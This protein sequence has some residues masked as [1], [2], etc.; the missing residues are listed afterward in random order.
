[1]DYFVPEK[2]PLPRNVLESLVWDRE[3]DIERAKE[4]FALPRAMGIA[5]L[6]DVKYPKRSLF[7]ALKPV[8]GSKTLPFILSAVRSSLHYGKNTLASPIDGKQQ[9]VN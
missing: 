1:M 2:A 5:K 4:R 8:V 7:D 9:L 6:A 3:R